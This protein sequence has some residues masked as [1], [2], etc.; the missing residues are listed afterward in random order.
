MN[1]S[2]A[3]AFVERH[4]IVLESARHPTIPSL[5]EAIAG[6]PL[7]G[8]WWSHP[9]GRTIF[10]ATRA[11]R[12]SA[13]VLVCRLIEGKIT[14]VHSRLWPALVRFADRFPAAA[15]ERVREVHSKSGAHRLESLAFPQ[16]VPTETT[17][18][19]KSLDA[20]HARAALE[21]LLPAF[22]VES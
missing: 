21:T 11:V 16:W 9:K 22:A 7:R 5:A 2:E 3:L 6:G 10:A 15:L 17:I 18:K 12:D 8:G 13:D 4:G 20:A 14:F 19:A 1:A